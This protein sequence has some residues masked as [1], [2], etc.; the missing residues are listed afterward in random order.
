MK[1]IECRLRSEIGL[2]A[3]SIGSISVQ[4]AV[5]ARM[6][7]LGLNQAEDYERQL[8]GSP[9]EWA[10]L[11][12][13]LVV[14]ETWFFR[15]PEAF[16]ALVRL[17]TD[18]WLPVHTTKPVRVLSLPCSTGEEPYSI[19]MA[20]AD[21]GVPPN[22][23]RI[24]AVDISGVALALARRGIYGKNSFRGKNLAFQTR[25]FRPTDEGFVFN[26]ALAQTVRFSQGNVFSDDFLADKAAY[27]F[28][29]CRNLLIYC[30]R[31]SQQ[32]A[33]E[34]LARLLSPAGV[35]FV[36][37]AE[38][39]VALEHGFVS[40]DFPLAFGCRKVGH[41]PV[42]AARCDKG[43]DKGADKGWVPA[44]LGIWGAG[45]EAKSAT[46]PTDLAQAR[47]LADAGR[48]AEAAELCEAHLRQTRD[49]AQA[50]YLLGLVR[51][52]RGDATAIDCFRKALYLEPEHYET[53]VQM[54]L[55][56]EKNGD[57]TAARAFKRRATRIKLKT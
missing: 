44:M 43:A 12:E 55:L 15:D 13:S 10:Q 53:L 22:R 8:S 23:F 42:R 47:C 6:N 16:G 28:I 3:A 40:A 37:A 31:P 25:H 46:V 39:P 51:D 34:R 56:A 48:L 36:G 32:K 17:V 49:S 2:D 45:Q 29:F 14:S 24:D 7:A 35:L 52:A 4:R 21:A 27:D 11:V 33:L 54:S 50:Y 30:D 41:A 9:S 38:H 1:E 5:R 57:V 19:A 20:L 18:A 26:P